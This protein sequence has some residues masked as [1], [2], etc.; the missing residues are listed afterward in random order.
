MAQVVEQVPFTE[1][2]ANG[3]TT[4]FP[5]NFQLIEVADLVVYADGV[6][7]PS[8]DYGVSGIGVQAGGAVTFVVA[9]A[10][11]V[12]I[13]LSREIELARTTEYQTLGDFKATVVNPDFN[14]LWMALQGFSARISG[15][16]RYPYPEQSAELPPATQRKGFL[17]GFDVVTGAA[18]MVTVAAGSAVSL[19]LAL[20]SSTGATLIG[21]IQAGTGAVLRTISAKLRDEV[22]V[23]DFGAVGDGVA[24][25]T[26]A[27]Q[28]A[29][30][31]AE[32]FASGYGLAVVFPRGDYL[33]S[34][35]TIDQSNVHMFCKS[36]ARLIKSGTSGDGLTIKSTGARIFGVKVTGLVFA[37]AT[38]AVSGRQ[39][40]C[41]N[42]GQ[43][44]IKD[45]TVTSFP[46]AAYRGIE[47]YNVSQSTVDI[48]VQNCVER[49]FYARDCVDITPI[50]GSRSD[51]NG[52]HGWEFDTCSGVY[53]T[54]VTGYN[55]TGNGFRAV[56]TIG[57][58]VLA[59]A[60]NSFHFYTSC[61]ADTSGSDN[62]YL[63]A[64]V[65]SDLK[66]CWGSTQKNATVDLH[67]FVVTGCVG[68]ELNA[69]KAL[70]NNAIGLHITGGSVGIQVNG[71]RYDGNG[72]QAGSAR[73]EGVVIATGT[74]VQ[75]D[76]VMMTDSQVSKTQQYG[77][78]VQ[79]TCDVL[80]MSNCNMEGNVVYPFA[81]DAVPV[82]FKESSNYTALS[83]SVASAA[84]LD[85]P[86]FSS[87][88]FVT[89][90][91]SITSINGLVRDRRITL[92]FQGALTVTDGGTL[93][94][95]GN[96]V[97][98]AGDTMTLVSDG[99]AWYE[100]ARS[101]N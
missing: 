45:V 79:A 68:V 11:G 7:V 37:N 87:V 51:A 3:V 48:E 70:T 35:L 1:S 101:V 16:L 94:L 100:V 75:M 83:A 99:A 80:L 39:I 97:T 41:E 46:A 50:A 77:L 55:N 53:A 18:T 20:A 6:V 9:P 24:N 86:I 21:W 43:M 33:Y 84:A 13:L 81:F 82:N 69:C 17:L 38:T 47:L 74:K 72:K 54:N 28:A 89:G 91:T 25:D 22:S 8:S 92:V 27:I 49:G 85:P 76:G 67:G 73:R 95:A 23:K 15:A 34:A 4:V 19:A 10:N 30:D 44:T 78:R 26:A 14:R 71:G 5:Y 40:Y 52:S 93:N 12:V 65:K 32:T 88:L 98:T 62:W 31:Y 56:S 63:S 61:I 57:S 36:D 60:G 2:T 58:P 29:I 42:V 66:G 90:T 59:T 64:L 96:F